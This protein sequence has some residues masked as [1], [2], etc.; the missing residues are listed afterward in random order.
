MIG[1][2]LDGFSPFA[3][4]CRCPSALETDTEATRRLMP[5]CD[6][7]VPGRKTHQLVR[8]WVKFDSSVNLRY[9]N[10]VLVLRLPTR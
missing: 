6:V 2:V 5:V 1:R 4:L 9:E 8:G 7:G 3:T 10:G